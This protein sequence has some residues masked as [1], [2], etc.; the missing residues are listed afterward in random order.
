MNLREFAN[1]LERLIPSEWSEQWD[2]PG[3]LSGDPESEVRKVAI[4]LNATLG[5]I[6]KASEIRADVLV[7]HHPAL[8]QPTSRLLPESL[9]GAS[10][11]HSIRNGIA[12]YA[13]HTNWD[14]SPVGVNH[15]LSEKAGLVGTLPLLPGQNGA[16]GIGAIGNLKEPLPL[17]E[18]SAF[19]RERWGLSWI[20]VLGE[21]DTEIRRLALCGGAGG[22]M[23]AEACRMKADAFVT[24]DLRYHEVLE[25]RFMG[26]SLLTC[27]HG[28]ME[29]ASLEGLCR[30]IMSGTGLPAEVLPEEGPAGFF[31]LAN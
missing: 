16:W 14:A 20:R 31:D 4:S 11:F 28:E 24:A 26:L 6:R 12:L 7:T 5:T 2:N 17:A 1:R 15:I 21:G 19:L 22:G 29:A 3:L 8:I 9:P 13:V 27:D 23:I 25:G 10:L 30:L 18:L